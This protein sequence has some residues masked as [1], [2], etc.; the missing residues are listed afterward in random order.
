VRLRGIHGGTALVLAIPL[1]IGLAS[2]A[3]AAPASAAGAASAR[4][5]EHDQS[6]HLMTLAERR[7]QVRADTSPAH[8][9]QLSRHLRLEQGQTRALKP[10]SRA[11]ILPTGTLPDGKLADKT[12]QHLTR[13]SAA[14]QHASATPQQASSS[15]YIPEV[16]DTWITDPAGGVTSA[17]TSCY[18]P[19]SAG[20][21][22][23]VPGCMGPN[24]DVYAG[25]KLT[26]TSEFWITCYSAD[27][28]E[29][30]APF[31]D[32]VTVY[33]KVI[34]QPLGSADTTLVS[35]FGS[36][37]V[38]ASA[39]PEDGGADDPAFAQATFTMPTT[40]S[41]PIVQGNN[42]G[43][44]N[45]IVQAFSQISGGNQDPN[46]T[47]QGDDSSTA[48]FWENGQETGIAPPAEGN[49]APCVPDSAGPGQSTGYG[50]DPVNTLEGECAETATDAALQTPG[51]PL[52]VQRNYSTAL[53]GSSGPLGPGWTM[54]WFA[55]LSINA[56]TG[57]AT[58]NAENGDQFTYVSDGGGT[59]SAPPGARS[60]LT[61]LSS[62]DYTLTTQQQDVLTFSSAGQL[63]SEVDSTGRGLTMTYSSGELTSVTDAAGQ[64]VTLA[65]TSGLLTK[66][67]LPNGQAITYGYT[68][69]LL[70]SAAI[71]GGS[72]GYT[73]KYAYNSADLLTTITDANGNV[74]LQNTYNAQD[75]VASQTNGAGAVTQFSYT[76]TSTGLTETDV[77]DPNGGIWTYLYGGNVLLETIDPLGHE[78][79]YAYNL[80]LEPVEVTDPLG[81]FN[82]LSYDESGNL[83][84]ET[85]PLGNIEQWTYDGSNNMLS[86]T[87]GNLNTWSYTYNSLDEVTSVTDPA[88]DEATYVY[89]GS[90]ELT[91]SV[92]PRGN[93]SGANA[94][95]YTTTYTYN[96]AGELAT[97]TNPDSGKSS[98]SYNS[99]GYLT[100]TTDP[101]GRVTSYSFDSDERLTA[102]TAPDGGKT[103]FG[104]N[105]TGELTSRIDPDGNTWTYTYN[106]G[107][108][109]VQATNPL[110]Q[111]SDYTYDGDGNQ[112]T[113]TSATGVV[114]TTTYDGDN[115]PTKV[116]YS[117]G[118]PTVTYAYDADSDVTTVTDGTGTR[119]LTYDADGDV[120][121]VKGPGSGSFS[122]T[123]DADRNVISRT[124]PDGKNVTYAYNTNEQV[125]SA[126]TGSSTTN[127][128]YDPAG[129]LVS[130]AM[131]DG[132]TQ[133]STYNG[134]EQLTAISDAKGSTVLDSYGLTLNADGQPTQAAVATDG[135]AQP[136]WYYGYDAAGR[137][138]SACDTS[139]DASACSA[140]A[141]G[142][143]NETAYT[144]D[145]AGNLT[146][147]ETDGVTTTRSYNAAEELTEAVAGTSTVSYAYNANGELTTAGA[148]TYSY[149]GAGELSQAVTSAG[150]YTYGYDASGDLASVSE[151]GTVTQGTVW[152][153]NNPLP[154]AAETTNA[155]GTA[156]ATYTYNPDGTLNSMITSAGSYG[157]VD[158]WLGSVTGLVNSSGSQVSKTSY[159]PYGT[160]TTTS[161]ASGAPTS[162]I[163]YAGSYN[164]P[165]S[166][167]LDDMRARDYDPATDEFTS[168]DPLTAMTGQPYLYAGDSPVYLTD[169]SG[170]C[171][172]YN[173][174]CS[175]VQPLMPQYMSFC[176]GGSAFLAAEAC[177]TSAR[178]G[179]WY[180]AL[181]GGIAT[182]GL[183]ASANAG[184]ILGGANNCQLDQYLSGST[185]EFYGGGGLGFG[186]V[187][188]SPF[189]LGPGN[190]GIEAGV[191]TPGAALMYLYAW[192]L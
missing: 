121:T 58:F 60:V 186:D 191:T 114:T 55:S 104:Y 189:K 135:A 4:V 105:G 65:Y 27:D 154:V 160:A 124:D 63:L 10:T 120:T 163:G 112:V 181:G 106:A 61:Q 81:G 80:F 100:S 69:G 137:L 56:T 164:V 148:D 75:Q 51:Y 108:E 139:S 62:G 3:G 152:D 118:T 116:T 98:F 79:Q 149:N 156:T 29:C 84:S 94:A 157:A 97:E 49:G 99:M 44:P 146:T 150:T 47:E 57:N 17:A 170:L 8:L 64:V 128:T 122:Y 102:V 162:S 109:L 92:D 45:A 26:V 145:Q 185:F 13:P 115:R 66:I 36:Q 123:Y 119:T 96:P 11:R 130:T 54:P 35:S 161:L 34:C 187:W 151:G 71:P 176:V 23:E 158:D 18:Y 132:V 136:T 87:D 31:S 111:S 144:Y 190:T 72:A 14:P 52:V 30:N 25:E 5:A 77:T 83:L 192:R 38:T 86:F 2:G 6:Q 183:I 142:A 7:A 133:A 175:L 180:F 82:T 182:P 113:V 177:I 15:I 126:T 131:P 159:S 88:G 155:S 42:G 19:P 184:Y 141:A 9:A 178:D 46:N 74:A 140:A 22:N 67:T 179:S 1:S 20:D 117:A 37:T 32:P 172:W 78:T 143:G 169:P 50:G 70:T 59:F 165:D 43:F 76:T 173:L 85:D 171:S 53:A 41:C 129:D 166:A 174:Y 28:D 153:I 93:V 48:F 147:S 24:G 68:G 101:A 16:S 107:D 89:N 91:S 12:V 103:Q 110:G 33:F 167:G 21:Y 90:G 168:A 40:S 125:A 138:A 73:T 188:G 39:A 127:Y 134:A 95:S